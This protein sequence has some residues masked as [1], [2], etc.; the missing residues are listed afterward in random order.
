MKYRYSKKQY[1]TYG[2]MT[3]F[4]AWVIGYSFYRI[5]WGVEISDE[6]FYI[7]DAALITK[8]GIPF[9]NMWMQTAGAAM[10][11][12]PLVKVYELINGGMDGIFLFMRAAFC[13]YRIGIFALIFFTLK[14]GKDS[15]SIVLTAIPLV[16]FYYSLIPMFSYTSV[17]FSLLLIVSALLYAGWEKISEGKGTKL[18]F[19]CGILMALVTLSYPTLIINCFVVLALIVY[20]FRP[21]WKK[22]VLQYVLGGSITA[23]LISIYLIFKAGSISNLIHGLT[24]M[25]VGNPYMRILRRMSIKN[26]CNIILQWLKYP[27]VFLF[28]GII[29]VI[30]LFIVKA[31]VVD[32]KRNINIKSAFSIG[33]P[34]GIISGLYYSYKIENAL[35]SLKSATAVLFIG[36]I[37]Y[38]IVYNKNKKLTAIFNI[39]AIPE[40]AAIL[41]LWKTVIGGISDRYYVVFPMGLL[42]ILYCYYTLD[43]SSKMVRLA[44]TATMSI[45]CILIGLAFNFGYLYREDSLG[46]L[47]TKIEQG[48]Y[49]GIYTSEQKA[50]SLTELEEYIKMNIDKNDKVLF[51][52][53]APMAYLMSDAHYCTPATWE[54]MA[55]HYGINDDTVMKEYFALIQDIPDKIVYIDT[56]RDELLSIEKEEYQFNDFVNTHYYSSSIGTEDIGIFRVKIYDRK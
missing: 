30:A 13:I 2:I 52:D 56:G 15:C 41:I 48:I 32:K 49:K 47:D 29:S 10:L 44:A 39:V 31:I 20:Y 14:K 16:P 18:V 23:I 22:Y 1:I 37:C 38:R 40:I 26:G 34:I 35:M 17:P 11:Y 46:R 45:F 9:V 25:L 43:F 5:F 24:M 36:V 53:C 21:Q 54:I 28:G 33:I 51:M 12:A 55:Y 4:I 7:A 19:I 3:L 27:V 50:N 8:G 6:I 42:C